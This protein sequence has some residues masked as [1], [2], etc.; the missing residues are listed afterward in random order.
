MMVTA[1]RCVGAVVA[2]SAVA[3]I[4]VVA[5]EF[6]SAILHP[7]PEGFKGTFEEVCQHVEGY[8]PWVLA[9]GAAAWGFAALAGTWTAGRLGN[10]GCVLF[11]GL[12]LLLAVGYNISTLPYPVWFKIASPLVIALAAVYGDRLSSQRNRRSQQCQ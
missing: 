3:L 9:V 2:G 1:L 8:P 5:F 11:L 7:F 4:L 10:R 6:L 12:L